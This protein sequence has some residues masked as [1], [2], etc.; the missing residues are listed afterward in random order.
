MGIPFPQAPLFPAKEGPQWGSKQ[1]RLQDFN[2]ALRMVLSM[3]SNKAGAISSSHGL[4]ATP[5]SWACAFGISEEDRA[6]LGYHIGKTKNITVWA[7]ARDR[8]AAPVVAMDRMLEAMR[9]GD[10]DPDATIPFITHPSSSSSSQGVEPNGPVMMDDLSSESD[11]EEDDSSDESEAHPGWLERRVREMEVKK[12]VEGSV[13]RHL[14]SRKAHKVKASGTVFCCGRP[15]TH[16]YEE[17]EQP[18]DRTE[19]CKGCF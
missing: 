17:G 2:A 1:G 10:F 9:A 4:K 3:V 19:L 6:A 11:D 14:E 7:Y 12:A 15:V 13:Y 8:L 16:M 5:L 18:S